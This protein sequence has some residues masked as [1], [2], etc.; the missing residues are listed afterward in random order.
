MLWFFSSGGVVDNRIMSREAIMNAAKLPSLDILRGE[1]VT[2]LNSSAGK[3]SRLLNRHQQDLS[4]N[5]EM[6]VKQESEN[7][8]TVS[9]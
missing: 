6:L 3:T 2:I 7:S 4:Q 8:N 9:H 5:L 1:L